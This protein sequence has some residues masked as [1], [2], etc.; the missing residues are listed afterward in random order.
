MEIGDMPAEDP[1][2]PC[3]ARTGDG[4]FYRV[5]GHTRSGS[6]CASSPPT[7]QEGLEGLAGPGGFR[8]DLFHRRKRE[9]RIHIPKT[10][11]RLLKDH[12]PRWAQHF[13]AR[14]RRNLAVEPKVLKNLSGPRMYPAQ[15]LPA[16]QR[17]QLG[18]IPV[19]WGLPSWPPA[20]KVLLVEDLPP[21]ML[22]LSTRTVRPDGHWSTGL[23]QPGPTRSWPRGVYLTTQ[24]KKKNTSK[25]HPYVHS[26]STKKKKTFF[27]GCR[28]I[29][30]LS[31][32]TCVSIAAIIDRKPPLT[33]LTA[34]TALRV[35]G[36]PAAWVFLLSG[37]GAV[38]TLTRKKNQRKLG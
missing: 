37:F 14:L 23:R 26:V 32:G 9:I 21:K 22:T 8:E 3:L 2:P 1:D 5:G 7:H 29:A 13:V 19:A 33:Q 15:P 25:N 34:D 12:F 24:E 30:F 11:E 10:R 28:D 20:A 31:Y 36:L 18:K 6:M 4:E 17:Q 38:I 16:G 35:R 27:G